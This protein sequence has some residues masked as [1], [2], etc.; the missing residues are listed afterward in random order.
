MPKQ[1]STPKSEFCHERR[2]ASYLDTRSEICGFL[3]NHKNDI[4]MSDDMAEILTDT[5]MDALKVSWQIGLETGL[6]SK[7][8]TNYE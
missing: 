8:R 4:I 2:L 1:N 5:I 6:K 7:K 3:Y